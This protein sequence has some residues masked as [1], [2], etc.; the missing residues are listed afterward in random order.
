[1]EQHDAA[2][3]AS[4][5]MG[6]AYHVGM[7]TR[8]RSPASGSSTPA[9]L[10]DAAGAAWCRAA[11]GR[12]HALCCSVVL[13][14][15]SLCRFKRQQ[16]ARILLSYM[17][18][19]WVPAARPCAR[20]QTH[21]AGH[22]ELEQALSTGGMRNFR[23]RAPVPARVSSA[24]RRA[25]PCRSSCWCAG[26]SLRGARCVSLRAGFAPRCGVRLALPTVRRMLSDARAP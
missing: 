19:E 4:S 23:T 15:C 16:M 3:P 11:R 2:G 8:V 5:T 22:H 26:T 6:C 12:Q 18:P 21:D 1:M 13:L 25:Q 14:S 7:Q 17:T 20:L 24:R 10:R 9:G